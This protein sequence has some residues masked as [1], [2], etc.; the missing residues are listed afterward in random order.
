M[1]SMF[2][3]HV[4]RE[5][6]QISSRSHSSSLSQRVPRAPIHN[7]YD[8]FSQT[9]FDA[10]IG[11]I[12]GTLRKALGHEDDAQGTTDDTSDRLLEHVTDAGL[13]QNQ[14]VEQEAESPLAQS[15]TR[16]AF[17]KGK[18][19]DPAEGPGFG[20]GTEDDPIELESDSDQEDELDEDLED[21]DWG[22]DEEVEPR[23]SQGEDTFDVNVRPHI[24]TK[25]AETSNGRVEEADGEEDEEDFAG[26]EAPQEDEL[27]EDEDLGE[28]EYD[29]AAEQPTVVLSDSEDEEDENKTPERLLP[30]VAVLN[31]PTVVDEENA[32][33]PS[34]VNTAFPLEYDAGAA[35]PVELQDAWDG[36]RKYAEDFYSGGDNLSLMDT[37]DP[38]RLNEND[39][40]DI[41]AFLTPGI[42]TPSDSASEVVSQPSRHLP[43]S[44]PQQEYLEFSDLEDESLF[45]EGDRGE[46]DEEVVEVLPTP[47]VSSQPHQGQEV[48]TGENEVIEAGMDSD[49][50]VVEIVSGADYDDYAMTTSEIIVEEMSQLNEYT[51]LLNGS[52]ELV[53]TVD[54]G[55]EIVSAETRVTVTTEVVGLPSSDLDETREMMN[56]GSLDTAGFVEPPLD[57]LDEIHS[58]ENMKID[59]VN[60]QQSGD[61]NLGIDGEGPKLGD[62]EEDSSA[63][64]AESP[65][66]DDDAIPIERPITH[67]EPPSDS[68]D[69]LPDHSIESHVA[70][71]PSSHSIHDEDSG[72]NQVTDVPFS[73]EPP[74]G[75]EEVD[76]SHEEG[77]SSTQPLENSVSNS[78]SPSATVSHPSPDPKKS[79]PQLS[80]NAKTDARYPEPSWGSDESQWQGPSPTTVPSQRP[81]PSS[82]PKRSLPQLSIDPSPNAPSPGPFWGHQPSPHSNHVQPAYQQQS[83]LHSPSPS[84]ASSS[85]NNNATSP[86]GTNAVPSANPLMSPYERMTMR[87][88]PFNTNVNP[89]TP[90]PSGQPNASLNSSYPSQ[91]T[92]AHVP[93][94]GSSSYHLPPYY[95]T[96]NA[97]YLRHP[98]TQGQVPPGG[99]APSL[100][101]TTNDPYPAALST[102]GVSANL[103]EESDE[104]NQSEQG[105]SSSDGEGGPSSKQGSLLKAGTE[106]DGVGSK[107]TP[108]LTVDTNIEN[109][110]PPAPPSPVTPVIPSKG[111]PKDHQPTSIQG[112]PQDGE[113]A[114]QPP[115]TQKEKPESSSVGG[116]GKGKAI[117]RPALEKHITPSSDNILPAAGNEPQ[118]ERVPLP[119][120]PEPTL[121]SISSAPANGRD[122]ADGR[123]P[124]RKRQASK[125]EQPRK[126]QAG[127]GKKAGVRTEPPV[128]KGKGKQTETSRQH[129][130][131]PSAASSG[132]SAV[133]KLLDNRSSSVGSGDGTQP[134]PTPARLKDFVFPKPVIAQPML[135]NHSKKGPMQHS[136]RPPVTLQ[137]QIQKRSTSFGSPIAGPSSQ[138]PPPT[139]HPT[140]SANSPVTRSNCRYHKISLPET[141]DGPRIF[142]LVPGCSL[143]DRELI[144]EEEIVDH[145]DATSEDSARMVPD[146]EYLDI[147]AYVIGIIRLLVGPD[148]E[149]EVYFLPKPGEERARKMGRKKSTIIWGDS[150]TATG[151]PLSP[152]PSSRDA[153]TS[154]NGSAN[155]SSTTTTTTRTRS[156]TDYDRVS[157]S[158]LTEDSEDEGFHPARAG[159]SQKTGS[160][161]PPLNDTAAVNGDT[162]LSPTK[163]TGNTNGKKPKR[164][165][166]LGHDAAEYMP[167]SG[168]ETESDNPEGGQ[169]KSPS[170]RS[171]KRPRTAETDKGEDGDR[172][173]KKPQEPLSPISAPPQTNSPVSPAVTSAAKKPDASEHLVK[174]PLVDSQRQALDRS[175]PG[176]RGVYKRPRPSEGVEEEERKK[177]KTEA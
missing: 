140:R 47:H 112:L 15:E 18:G 153:P 155:G 141:E 52:P 35:Q 62:V 156:N 59:P 149:Q 37:L 80:I 113:P 169:K 61:S 78:I 45:A 132:A 66:P 142:F 136:H 163:F 46:S 145:G 176:L 167:I 109:G 135:H 94:I 128:S 119:L 57:D 134:S 39:R 126:T 75:D 146:I 161:A 148:K 137:T 44:P 159:E 138:P 162:P 70:D 118:K 104:E 11:G 69:Q 6:P 173:E 171:L 106:L 51:T 38:H 67:P 147:N 7:P 49:D 165:K 97:H 89:A 103:D 82:D 33:Q 48:L 4:G 139:H 65:R 130:E 108:V 115:L 41:V 54:G 55:T 95:S 98:A 143:T 168:D 26:S 10:W 16:D 122:D 32:S 157:T 13:T 25:Y 79:L 88:I 2:P 77:S 101:V 129:S 9:D 40:S 85:T 102:P 87:W 19:R 114:E 17:R 12:T 91:P 131:T 99:S 76:D 23:D 60:I 28:G 177:R 81:H 58:A 22:V 1:P 111:Q 50:E 63:E 74:V 172:Q 96:R 150:H 53:G 154:A 164:A 5:T 8:K 151:H 3:A 117:Q 120:T 125:P 14:S 92:F 107:S 34:E 68:S 105:N 124:K 31:E 127:K 71:I 56:V 100:V 152:H 110:I 133:A 83:S 86:H 90:N 64:R 93:L 43:T 121:G 29:D 73:D 158:P 24:V 144:K 166:Y 160:S 123:A 175:L 42:I 27:D 174:G 20:P 30:S 84:T 36:P 170:K 21:G 72:I 116:K